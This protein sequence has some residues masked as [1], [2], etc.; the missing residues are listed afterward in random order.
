MRIKNSQT[1]RPETHSR[2]PRIVLVGQPNSGK[3]TLFN[4]VAGYRS[5]SA[6]FPGATVTYTQSHVRIE[7]QTYDLVD[8]PGI[9]SLT[10]LDQAD[11]ESQ[12][13]LLTRSVDVM[14]NV[15]DAST[16]SRSLELTLQ[17]LELE[18]PVVLCLNMSDEAERKGIFIDEEKLSGILGIPV[19]K[20]VASLGHGV[21]E[22]FRQ[23]IETAA[24]G[25]GARHIRGNRDVE[26]VIAQLTRELK[27]QLKNDIPF[28]KHLLATKLLEKDPY[29]EERLR[30][31]RPDLMEIVSRCRRS[32]SQS[33]GKSSDKVINAE[34]HELS[35][36][37]FEKVTRLDRPH[38]KFRDRVDN[39]LMHNFWG[40]VFLILVLYLFFQAVFR[41]GKVLETP[42]LE[43]TED[44][45][46]VVKN[47]VKPDALFTHLLIDAIRGLNGGI[48]ILLPYLIPFLLGLSLIEDVGYLPRIAF[49]MDTFMHRIGLHGKAIIPAVLGYGCNV[50][51]VMA[52]RIMESGRDR[53]IASVISVMVPCAARMIIIVGLVGRFLGGTAAFGIYLLNL[54]VIALSAKFLSRMMP[55]V[56]PGMVL[57]IPA[58]QIPRMK[59]ILRKT[60]FRLKDFVL[61]ALPLLV[62]GSVILGLIQYAGWTGLADRLLR[63]VTWL[64]G[65]PVQ[66]GTTLIFGVLRKEMSLLMLSQA[67]NVGRPQDLI[68]VLS[69][70]QVLVFTIFVVFYIP[71]IA[72]LGAL[73]RQVGLKRVLIILGFTFTLA[74]VLGVAARGVS[75]LIF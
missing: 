43:V 34:R 67:L 2:H 44:I 70:G 52:T 27:Q 42:I 59:I 33:H 18:I 36:T 75:A 55:E 40:Y 5:V 37:I 47:H 39:L 21:K 71:C 31:V 68:S 4:E 41:F 24:E 12:R 66:V 60:W 58:F 23:A 11:R 48:A 73:F 54:V 28:S 25:Y 22:L 51:A 10:S 64:L 9:Y 26:L 65:L 69:Y 19:V 62:V 46:D 16:L 6:N 57:E 7:H 63:P 74:M 56:S 20:T 72:T 49:L 53:F 32:L 15:V 61:I 38:I 8:L 3:S 14:I 50:P 35:M 1:K 30:R 13:Y 17:L 29:F 45:I